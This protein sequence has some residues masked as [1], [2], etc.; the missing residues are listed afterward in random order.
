MRA[1][2]ARVNGDKA[3]NQRQRQIKVHRR[4]IK[5]KL[6][7]CTSNRYRSCSLYILKLNR[8]LT[9]RPTGSID[10]LRCDDD[11]FIFCS[12][13]SSFFFSSFS[14]SLRHVA[15][16][17]KLTVCAFQLLSIWSYRCDQLDSWCYLCSVLFCSAYVVHA[18]ST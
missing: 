1:K 10:D 13:P 7:R 11:S 17:G 3:E 9:P 15:S 2:R 4:D 8:S 6:I 14:S 18:I 5:I 12:R 16:D